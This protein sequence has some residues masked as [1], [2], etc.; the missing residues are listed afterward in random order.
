MAHVLFATDLGAQALNAARYAV[1]LFGVEGNTFTVLH[2]FFTPPSEPGTVGLDNELAGRLAA[3]GVATFAQ[4]LIGACPDVHLELAAVSAYGELED[5]LQDMASEPER[6][7]V[8]VM[9]GR[10][11]TKLERTLLGS[12]TASVI[13]HTGLPV[14]TVPAGTA[15]RAPAR[16]VLADD[17]GPV[18]RDAVKL[19][20]DIARWSRSEVKIVHVVPADRLDE[21]GV[22]GSG[23]DQLLG[24]IPRSYHTV[25]GDNTLLVLSELADQSDA[26]LVVVMHRQRGL[27]D[28]LFHHSVATDLALHTHIPMLILQQHG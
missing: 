25:S 27:L 2:T 14:L 11:T 16:I 8:V 21:E 26:D 15:Y 13:R 12:N 17:G 5:V 22:E 19:L 9:G 7:D 23:Y 18:E 1:S 10:T 6:P 28:Q 24:A 4:A 20:V 3:E